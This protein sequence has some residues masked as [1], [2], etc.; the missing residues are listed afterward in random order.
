[1]HQKTLRE[2]ITDHSLHEPFLSLEEVAFTLYNEALAEMEREA[3][4]K[5]GLA[6][7]RRALLHLGEVFK[8]D[9][10]ATLMCFICSCKYVMHDGFDKFGRQVRKGHIDFRL[11]LIHI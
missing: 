6:T 9:N 4:P 1:M 8:E 5:L 7:E 11:S 3:C 10:V 2:L